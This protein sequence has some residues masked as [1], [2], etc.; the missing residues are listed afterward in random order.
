MVAESGPVIG[1]TDLYLHPAPLALL[2][3]KKQFGLTPAL[4]HLGVTILDHR[5]PLVPFE[6]D[7]AGGHLKAIRKR[8]LTL[9]LITHRR[10]RDD[11]ATVISN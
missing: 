6:G 2:F 8:F 5:R 9:E 3:L 11:F 4:V 10:R 1:Y 7:G